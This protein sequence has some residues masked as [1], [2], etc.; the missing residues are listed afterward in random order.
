MTGIALSE[1]V[2]NPQHLA[3]MKDL[4]VGGEQESPSKSSEEDRP[5]PRSLRRRKQRPTERI[6]EGRSVNGPNL[7][8]P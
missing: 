6:Q 2:G 3:E 4:G 7:P 1:A 8:L 5:E